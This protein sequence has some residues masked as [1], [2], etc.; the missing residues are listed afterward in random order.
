MP[1]LERPPRGYNRRDKPLPHDLIY[2]FFLGADASSKNACAV[3]L[4][5]TSKISNDPKSI[6][7]NPLNSAFAVDP[8]A[9]ICYDSIVEKMSILTTIGL[10]QAALNTD[11]LHHASIWHQNIFGVFED[12]WDAKDEKTSATIKAILQLTVNTTDEDV[13]PNYDATDLGST[14]HPL[15]TVTATETFSTRGLTGSAAMEN[16]PFDIEEYKDM[17]H[18]GTN[19]PKLRSL[20][21]KLKKITLTRQKPVV[22]IFERKFVPKA[23]KYGR[24]YMAFIKRIIFPVIGNDYQ[25]I[26]PSAVLTPAGVYVNMKIRFNEWNPDFDQARM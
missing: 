22:T 6:E 3:Q 10:T 24:R 5:G 1:F 18:Y 20:T 14:L 15:S 13:R 2:D 26:D 16:V 23:V 4:L 17:I 11:N 19:G 12:T 8:G 25:S 9:L 7:V 21:G